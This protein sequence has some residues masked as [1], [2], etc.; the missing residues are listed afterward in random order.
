MRGKA[1]GWI[2]RDHE[3]LGGSAFP[4]AIVPHV[5][6]GPS[7]QVG[8][9]FLLCTDGPTDVLDGGDLESLLYLSASPAIIAEKLNRQAISGGSRDNISVVVGICLQGGE[10]GFYEPRHLNTL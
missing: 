8:E 1:S 4:L 2:A 9:R 6:V 10:L 5:S 7:M 3:A